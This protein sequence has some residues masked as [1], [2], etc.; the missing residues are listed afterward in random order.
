MQ[1]W[2]FQKTLQRKGFFAFSG[3]YRFSSPLT[4]KQQQL[5]TS[6]CSRINFLTALK[7]THYQPLQS[8]A[9][10]DSFWAPPSHSHFLSIHLSASFSLILSHFLS[11]TFPLFDFSAFFHFHIWH[12]CEV[13]QLFIYLIHKSSEIL[14]SFCQGCVSSVIGRQCEM[15]W[16]KCANLDW[17][18][19]SRHVFS[20]LLQLGPRLTRLLL[21]SRLLKT[22]RHGAFSEHLRKQDSSL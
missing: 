1:C 11:F 21:H 17:V 15:K 2:L 19:S 4:D 7:N 16:G 9:R 13:C 14:S 18:S 5:H 10:N 12:S 8:D 6:A 20:V 22:E 3:S